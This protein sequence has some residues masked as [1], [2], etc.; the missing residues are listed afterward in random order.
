VKRSG[1]SALRIGTESGVRARLFAR[2]TLAIVDGEIGTPTDR[3]RVSNTVC[4]I[5]RAH[6]GVD[7]RVRALAN[8]SSS[9]RRK[10]ARRRPLPRRLIGS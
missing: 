5:W 8:I 2:T 3:G 4:K 1:A 10:S 9:A 7:R 6:A